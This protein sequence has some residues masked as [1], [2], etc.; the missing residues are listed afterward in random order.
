MP[1]YPTLFPHLGG[2]GIGNGCGRGPSLSLLGVRPISNNFD[3][4][5][6]RSEGRSAR[7]SLFGQSLRYAIIYLTTFDSNAMCCLGSRILTP[8]LRP[9]TFRRTNCRK[10]YSNRQARM[11]CTVLPSRAPCRSA[12]RLRNGADH[13]LF[14]SM[15]KARC[16]AVW[17]LFSL[18]SLLFSD[19]REKRSD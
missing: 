9:S 8:R 5:I 18:P 19:L 16:A 6:N 2:R 12:Q 4:A 17:F 3:A 1:R 10:R 15:T 14:D 13:P 7:R 11:N